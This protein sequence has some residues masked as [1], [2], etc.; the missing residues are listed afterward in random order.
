MSAT[1][2]KTL[3]M[4][5]KAMLMASISLIHT[6]VPEEQRAELLGKLPLYKTVEEQ[7]SHFD[8]QVN[9]KQIENTI[10]KPM[11]KE[12]KKQEKL[13][14]KPVK[15]KKPRAPRKKKEET[16]T[17]PASEVEAPLVIENELQMEE[18]YSDVSGNIVPT[19]ETINKNDAKSDQEAKPKEPKP[20]VAKEAKPKVAKEAKPKVAKEE[21]KPEVK[22]EP[23]EEPK[24][25]YMVKFDNVRY[26]TTD[27]DYQNGE[28]WDDGKDEDCDSSPEKLVGKIENG[29]PIFN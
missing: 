11:L 29:K 6:H 5:Y 21:A 19:D 18:I 3:P 25:Y 1:I 4:K 2:P 26:W 10:Y 16:T 27:E 22:A 9:L 24:D 20:K 28:L 13:A 7:I 12:H 8:E 23:E 14:N 15:E 17:E